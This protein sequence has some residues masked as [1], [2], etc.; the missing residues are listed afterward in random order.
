MI[1]EGLAMHYVLGI[2]RVRLFQLSSQLGLAKG[3]REGREKHIQEM[4]DMQ[5]KNRKGLW[6]IDQTNQ[7][8]F[9]SHWKQTGKTT[10][11]VFCRARQQEMSR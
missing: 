6:K 4:K 10:L 7:A 2:V 8:T 1:K 11:A 9:S 3:R 5:S